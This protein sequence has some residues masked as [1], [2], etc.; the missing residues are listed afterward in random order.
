MLTV[1]SRHPAMN[2]EGCITVQDVGNVTAEPG[3]S[4]ANTVGP[5]R[6]VGNRSLRHTII[7]RSLVAVESAGGETIAR[8]LQQEPDGSLPV[9]STHPAADHQA[10]FN[11][12]CRQSSPPAEWTDPV[13]AGIAHAYPGLR[14]FTDGS[15]FCG[16]VT[17]IIGQSISLA[18]ATAAQRRL[19]MCFGA[20]VE[21]LG[22]K[23]APLPDAAQLSEASVELI[24]SSGVT[25]KRAE[26]LKAIAREV[27]N[28]NLPG[29]VDANADMEA[30]EKM[31][32]A[33]PM[34]GKWTA[35]SALLWGIGAPDAFPTGDVALLRAARLAY[36]RESMTLKDLDAL[37]DQWRPFR[38][39]ATRL[40][41]TSLFG[42]AW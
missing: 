23:M 3:F 2:G 14:S 31:L 27:I 24:R 35:A 4:L 13:I 18:S 6:W 38:G 10:W 16:L 21:I 39:I 42:P 32:L 30:L 28:G 40:L 36:D 5:A 41:W 33:L 17:S 37:A 25:W 12:L 22:G 8:Q 19:T 1:F 7:D 20:G 9:R 34:V 29:D 15:L 26:A 11:R